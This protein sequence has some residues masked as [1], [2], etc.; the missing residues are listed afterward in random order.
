MRG[1]PHHQVGRPYSM[2]EGLL[3]RCAEQESSNVEDCRECE[4]YPHPF[5]SCC[6]FLRRCLGAPP[7]TFRSGDTSERD[8]HGRCRASDRAQAHGEKRFSVST[9]PPITV[10]TP[11]LPHRFPVLEPRFLRDGTLYPA[12]D[13]PVREHTGNEPSAVMR[14]SEFPFLRSCTY[15]I[16]G[17]RVP[18][19]RSQSRCRN[20][21]STTATAPNAP[22]KADFP[23][24]EYRPKPPV[25]PRCHCRADSGEPWFA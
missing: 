17:P 13:T 4:I 23:R 7:T 1:A 3:T 8:K 6:T 10:P 9:T 19:P 21:P 11:N 20:D 12:R 14:T 15:S 22:A 25:S 16:L 2:P 18:A 5:T 24:P